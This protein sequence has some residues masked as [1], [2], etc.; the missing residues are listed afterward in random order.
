MAR[1][2]KIRVVAFISSSLFQQYTALSDEFGLSRSELFRMALTRSHRSIA[3]WCAKHREEFSVESRGSVAST[4]E[5][6]SDRRSA[7]TPSPVAQLTGY[8]RVLVD[9]DPDLG[10]EQVRTMALAQSVVVGVPSEEAEEVVTDLLEHLF[11]SALGD[12]D[13]GLGSAGDDLD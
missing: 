6:T 9:Q 5:S 1:E 2:S 13:D 4:S 12:S 11:P 3:L 10:V 8:C 7:P